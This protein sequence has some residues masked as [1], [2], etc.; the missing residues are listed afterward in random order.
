[1]QEA[2]SENG[3]RKNEPGGSSWRISLPKLCSFIFLR[4]CFTNSPNERDRHDPDRRSPPASVLTHLQHGLM[5]D[6]TR[7]SKVALRAS[8]SAPQ[9]TTPRPPTGPSALPLGPT[10]PFPHR[11]ARAPSPAPYHPRRIARDA[12]APT[13]LRPAHS[14]TASCQAAP[15]RGWSHAQD[16]KS[17]TKRGSTQGE[18]HA[19][20]RARPVRL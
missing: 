10:A 3:A 15:L 2:F 16:H 5:F 4:R 20:P 8:H 14:A 12:P 19:T 9:P 11:I 7:M 13:W 18:Q 6:A 1:M 17:Y